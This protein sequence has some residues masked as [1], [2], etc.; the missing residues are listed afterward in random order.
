MI[1]ILLVQQSAGSWERPIK[2]HI[3]PL[4][5]ISAT[6]QIPKDFNIKLIDVRIHGKK[7]LLPYIRQKNILIGLSVL[8]GQSI[9]N[10][11]GIIRFIKE[12]NPS[13][14]IILGGIHPTIQPEQTLASPLVD[15]IVTGPGETALKEFLI[16]RSGPRIS[17]PDNIE[18]LGYKDSGKL[19]INQP[20]KLTPEKI[21]SFGLPSYDL[22]DIK[23]Y[24][25]DYDG[26]PS[27][28]IE[29][30][31]GC[32]QRCAFCVNSAL[33]Q[34]WV[35][36]S[37]D[38]VIKH[39]EHLYYTYGVKSFIFIDWDFFTDLERARQICL[40]LIQKKIG[41][42]WV[43]QGIHVNELL[44][45]DDKFMRL[46]K[47]S[48][49]VEF[50]AIGVESGS[51]RIL[52][53]MNKGYNMEELISLNKNLSRYRIALK[54]TFIIG[55]PYE[56]YK[57][58]QETISLALKLNSDNPYAA[59]SSF[60][61]YTPYPGTKFFDQAVNL[62]FNPPST[63]EEWGDVR[64]WITSWQRN[65]G[66]RSKL[67]KIHFLSLF[68]TA[69]YWQKYLKRFKLLKPVFLIYSKIAVFR[70]KKGFFPFMP[71]FLIW[72]QLRRN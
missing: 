16:H 8:T 40:Q 26:K 17:N 4:S 55:T 39:I 30:S 37:A 20:S 62:G 50:C 48:G 24:L 59:N 7:A 72:K 58:L 54:Y 49:F 5:L 33:R 23:Q 28:Q 6:R 21:D 66:P 29:S 41:I 9:K 47:E 35:P 25:I 65:R 36:Y 70:L 14:Q 15:Y 43:S 38:F 60:Y 61:I 46:L 56:Q 69:V 57:D 19:F 42:S 2:N 13:A 45:I 67:E 18:G 12:I 53:T 71:E 27:I 3:L 31:R 52:K 1:D 63:L 32:N 44:K 11:L 10:A 22:V 64:G 68:T 51:K 34:N